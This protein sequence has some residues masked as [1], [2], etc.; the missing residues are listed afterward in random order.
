MFEFFL[1]PENILLTN[2]M[3]IQLTDFGSSVIIEDNEVSQT[4]DNVNTNG[5]KKPIQR[6]NSF[7]GTAQFVAPEIL[8][9]GPVHY[10]FVRI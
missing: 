6:K 3:H 7:V 8:Q 1:K 2:D 9:H 4:D 5:E 10:G